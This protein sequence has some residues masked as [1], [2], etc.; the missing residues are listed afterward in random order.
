MLRL[1]SRSLMLWALRCVLAGYAVYHLWL[2]VLCLTL[3]PP[4]DG[5]DITLALALFTP[6]LAWLLS[7][8]SSLLG[9][10][11]FGVS[12]LLVWLLTAFNYDVCT[13]G[14]CRVIEFAVSSIAY[15][16]WDTT[17]ALLGGA[18]LF[19]WLHRAEHS[20]KGIA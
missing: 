16:F 4:Q 7:L 20:A 1:P 19:Y 6:A 12:F 9:A 11:A 14:P 17:A 3:R 5:R 2:G 15:L 13:P 8:R 10:W 18:L